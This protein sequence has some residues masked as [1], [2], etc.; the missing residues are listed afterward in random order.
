MTSSEPSH[1]LKA[2][3]PLH[4]PSPWELRLPQMNRGVRR[5]QTFIQP[6]AWR[7]LPRRAPTLSC[8]F[9]SEPLSSGPSNGDCNLSFASTHK[10]PI[11]S[12]M[13]RDFDYK[14]LPMK[15]ESLLLSITLQ[16]SGKLERGSWSGTRTLPRYLSFHH[17]QFFEP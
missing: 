7:K 8:Y 10:A 14:L 12:W 3:R 5:P 11:N 15:H 2:P 4:V 1:L 17:F 13:G 6:A 16:L 9:P